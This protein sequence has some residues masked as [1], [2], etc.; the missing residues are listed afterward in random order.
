MARSLI[1][2]GILLLFFGS[3]LYWIL[4]ARAWGKKLIHNRA[5][6]LRVGVVALAAYVALFAYNFRW[7][8]RSPSPTHFSFKDAAFSAPF[9]WWLLSSL[10]AFLIVIMI[11]IVRL[12]VRGLAW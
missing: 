4:R 8:G 9:Q 11:W 12:L 10:A 2:G 5:T 6:R 7:F 1:F 3:Q